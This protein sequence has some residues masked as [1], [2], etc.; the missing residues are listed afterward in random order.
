MVF[1]IFSQDIHLNTFFFKTDKN[2][3]PGIA[4]NIG[5]ENT[6]AKYIFFLDMDD[7]FYCD[8]ALETLLEHLEEKPYLDVI[9]SK[10]WEERYGEA[11]YF[12][13]GRLYR[14]EFIDR[15]NSRFGLQ[16][17]YEDAYFDNINNLNGIKSEK[18]DFISYFYSCNNNSIIADNLL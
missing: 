17:S 12:G 1:D 8:N 6:Y 18:I 2:S 16:F 4:R 14:K 5:I 7:Y 11:S 10:D 15:H 13:H 3:G 9:Y